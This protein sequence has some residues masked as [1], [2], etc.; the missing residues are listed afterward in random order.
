MNIFCITTEWCAFSPQWMS[1]LVIFTSSLYHVKMYSYSYC[2]WVWL[3][4]CFVLYHILS[5]IWPPEADSTDLS[6]LLS[7]L[8][9][10]VSLLAVML[11]CAIEVFYWQ[12]LM[13]KLN[14]LFVFLAVIA[15]LCRLFLLHI[16]DLY[17]LC[18]SI[19]GA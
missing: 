15:V 3:L 10:Y 16:T 4:H 7:W 2:L 8:T 17:G 13:L 14:I 6:V 1:Y 12:V 5:S 9:V 19:S 11:C 18:H